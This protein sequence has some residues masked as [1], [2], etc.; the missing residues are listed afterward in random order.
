M[1]GACG[2]FWMVVSY[3]PSSVVP[4]YCFH[5]DV[6]TAREAQHYAPLVDWGYL[7]TPQLTGKGDTVYHVARGKA[8]G[9][10]HVEY[11]AR[12]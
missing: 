11:G 7:T 10:R 3:Q 8:L 9:G 12:V 5:Y 4:A 1:F 2:R 6:D